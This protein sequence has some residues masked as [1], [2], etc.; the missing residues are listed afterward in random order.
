MKVPDVRGAESVVAWW[1]GWIGFHDF[2][3]LSV[4]EP[5]E[6]EGEMRIHGWVTHQET[7]ERGYF[8]TSKDCIIRICLTGIR[9]RELSSNELPAIIFHLG[10]EAVPGGWS[11]TWDSSYGCEGRLEASDATI[12]LEPG[13]QARVADTT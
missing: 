9:S 3:L 11:V 8:K 2:C 4:P 13:H 12:L 1:G 5:G 10:V 7:D 6:H